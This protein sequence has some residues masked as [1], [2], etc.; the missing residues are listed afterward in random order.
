M[1]TFPCRLTGSVRQRC[2][3]LFSRPPARRL[4]CP[5]AGLGVRADVVDRLLT[6]P[7]ADIGGAPDRVYQLCSVSNQ[8]GLILEEDATNNEGCTI[9]ELAGSVITVLSP[10]PDHRI[11]DDVSV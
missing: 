3:T 6:D 7:Y 1:S 8:K 5:D 9:F 2:P 4:L 11:P 10:E